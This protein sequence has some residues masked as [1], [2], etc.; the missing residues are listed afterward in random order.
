VKEDSDEEGDGVEE[1]SDVEGDRV[2]EDSDVEGD[3]VE[4]VAKIC[5]EGHII[6]SR[7]HGMVSAMSFH[8]DIGIVHWGSGG[9]DLM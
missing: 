3:R 9:A 8:G 1:D 2:E 7:L 5:P 6:C 4:E